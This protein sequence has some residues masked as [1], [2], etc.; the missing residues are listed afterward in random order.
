MLSRDRLNLTIFDATRRFQIDRKIQF[1]QIELIIFFFGETRI[2]YK[3]YVRF[4]TNVLDETSI[5]Y[6]I[7]FIAFVIDSIDLLSKTFQDTEIIVQKAIAS[8]STEDSIQANK[9]MLRSKRLW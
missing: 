9:M 7:Q 1:L 2:V 6:L 5:S 8:V 4:D 3:V